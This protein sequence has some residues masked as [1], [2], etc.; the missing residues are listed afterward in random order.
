MSRGLLKKFTYIHII[1]IYILMFPVGVLA[2]VS[3]DMTARPSVNGRLHV[4]GRD[5]LDESDHA[6]QL[7]GVSAQGLIRNQGFINDSLFKQ[8][9]SDWDCHLIRL[10]VHASTYDSY[11]SGDRDEYYSMIKN[12]IDLAISNDMYVIVDWH[13]LE[14]GNPNDEIDS[15]LEFFQRV[16]FDYSNCPNIIFEICNEPNGAVD[17]S[18]VVRYAGRVIPVIRSRMKDAVIL[19]GTPIFDHNLG[20][21][22]IR[23]LDYDNVM[24]V[25]HFYA[26]THGEEAQDE[27][28]AAIREG[29]PVFVSECG[30]CEADGD[31]T[32]DF[33]SAVSWFE[34]LNEYN[35]SYTVW[36]LSG[37]DE[38]SSFFD[39]DFDPHDMI[40][41]NDL[42]VTGRWVRELIRGKE[43]GTISVP[44]PVVKRSIYQRLRALIT[45]S[46]EIRGYKAI[47]NWDTL[48]CVSAGILLFASCGYLLYRF[49]CYRK[50][51]TYDDVVMKDV[52]SENKALKFLTR[53]VVV[54]GSFFTLIYLGW[55]IVYSVPTDAGLAAV[56][57]NLLLLTV[58]IL[59]FI[60]SLVMY[61]N[62]FGR[63]KHPLPSIPDDA[64]PDVDIFIA[65]YNEPPELLKRTING[66]T[67]LK[68]PDLNKIH[69]WVCD[70]NRRPQMRELA[71][72]MGVGY[73]D[74]P[75]NKGAKAGNL[76]NAMAHTDSPYIVTLDADMIVKSDFLLKT[77]PYF[78]D[79]ELRE[80]GKPEEERHHLGLLQTPQ[81]FYDPDVFQHALY[82]ERRAPNE[83]DFFYRT[84]EPAKTATN[85]V[86]YGGSNT[87]ISRKA[88]ED[89]GGFYT[90][91]I[92]EDFATG[93]L[94]EAAGYVSL[95][96]S[97]PLASGQTPHTFKE[98]IQQ[99]TRW[100]RGVIVT[101][102]KLGILR[103]RDLN[104][105]QKTNYLSS[106]VYWYSPVKN[107]IY[108]FGILSHLW[109]NIAYR[110]ART[111][112]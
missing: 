47:Y 81:C 92:T 101:A 31:G 59:G 18:D 109:Q 87:V 53:A 80:Q 96:L 99:R 74:R 65:T 41:D 49:V 1:I 21:P 37:K 60:E 58:E 7:R 64:W 48:A 106:V 38:S 27:I 85:S 42:T 105:A 16:T 110:V 70:D 112:R 6:V 25:Y 28:K 8:L 63:R 20:S 54:L 75:D 89:I 73:F 15:A 90:G 33:A 50:I 72:E 4:E 39:I 76:N 84:I 51:F 24:Y 34:L 79:V 10:A 57:A 100:A 13:M 11:K 56:I 98:H 83:Q 55:R 61:R 22:V 69:I 86:I 82:S 93:L 71:N 35:I 52:P 66:C 77:I 108:I 9:S 14:K 95:G 97:E 5:L 103:R 29:L 30:V 12:G 67:H 23:P 43:P 17:W 68:Y 111:T 46:L 36:G 2:A 19:V 104:I 88:L 78:V 94:I 102:R 107:L 26:A 32:I 91:S 3:P 45:N 40:R 44:S 62:L